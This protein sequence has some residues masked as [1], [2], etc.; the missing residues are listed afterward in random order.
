M[1]CLAINEDCDENDEDD[2]NG[3][4]QDGVTFAQFASHVNELNAALHAEPTQIITG[5]YPT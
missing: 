3:N 4:Y 1:N 5:L 2:E